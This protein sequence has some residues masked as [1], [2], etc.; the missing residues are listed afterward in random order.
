M[1]NLFV[2]RV[3]DSNIIC[4]DENGEEYVLDIK[5]VPSCTKEGDVLTANEGV[6]VIDYEK[7]NE[8]RRQIAKLRNKI[9]RNSAN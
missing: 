2:D 7:T 3:E 8:K 4:E 9:Y 5:D 6:I 1:K